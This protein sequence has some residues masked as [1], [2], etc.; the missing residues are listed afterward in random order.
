VTQKGIRIAVPVWLTEARRNLEMLK[1][2]IDL[3]KDG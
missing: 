2:E 1:H 3:L